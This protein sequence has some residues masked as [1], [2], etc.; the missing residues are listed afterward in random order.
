MFGMLSV[1]A[2]M[3]RELIV[4]NT[5]DGLAQRGRDFP[6]RCSTPNR[7]GPPVQY[8]PWAEDSVGH[9]LDFLAQACSCPRLCGDQVF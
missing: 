9:V 3:Q 4:A 1:L 2:E 6:F 8:L 5:M 7:T